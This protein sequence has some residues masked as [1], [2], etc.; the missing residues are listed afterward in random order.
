MVLKF[1]APRQL[2]QNW[3]FTL[4][5]EGF[6]DQPLSLTAWTCPTK[7]DVDL[8][9]S[10]PQ[11]KALPK[12]IRS[13]PQSFVHLIHTHRNLFI[14]KWVGTSQMEVQYPT[15]S[16]LLSLTAGIFPTKF[17]VGQGTWR[18][19]DKALQKTTHFMLQGFVHLNH[20]PRNL[21]LIKWVGTSQMEVL[22]PTISPLCSFFLSRNHPRYS[23]P[24]F[25]G[26]S[27]ISPIYPIK[28]AQ[29]N[30]LNSIVDNKY[31]YL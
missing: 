13:M 25:V 15:I 5:L 7:F 11:N 17:Y 31:L 19:Q 21:F 4:F 1:C 20:T 24:S 18:P 12:T 16:Q 23:S 30:K 14:I 6:P 9:T 26:F 3:N 8:G 10:R 29:I 27:S 2:M 28:P 22:Y